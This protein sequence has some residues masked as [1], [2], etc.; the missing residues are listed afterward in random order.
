MTRMSQLGADLQ[1]RK[2]LMWKLARSV[3]GMERRPLELDC[4]TRCCRRGLAGALGWGV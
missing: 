1:Q 4:A 3:Q 2:V